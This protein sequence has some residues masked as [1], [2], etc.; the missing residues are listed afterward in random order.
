MSD[1]MVD[2]MLYSIW[3]QQPP[4]GYWII[5]GST[6]VKSIKF[7]MYAKPNWLHRKM[8]QWLMGWKWENNNGS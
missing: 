1:H 7:S 8:M 4:A 3:T 5:P 2:A 6:Y